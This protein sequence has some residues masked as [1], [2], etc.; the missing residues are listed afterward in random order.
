MARG[1]PVNAPQ[2][3]RRLL[4]MPQPV[5]FIL[6]GGAA[7][8]INW[9]VRFPLS[10]IMPFAAAV[11]AANVIGMV[12][13][14]VS[15]RLFVFPDSRRLVTHQLRDFIVVNLVSMVVVVLVSVLFADFLLPLL[16][17]RWQVEAISHAVGIGAGAVSNYFGHRQFSFARH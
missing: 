6:V 3:R 16:G 15:Y 14:F 11:A 4:Q 5:R 17:W 12:F 13:G 9:L 8:L 10:Y 7:A 1:A 2:A